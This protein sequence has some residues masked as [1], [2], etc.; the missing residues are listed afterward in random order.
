MS[1]KVNRLRRR[2]EIEQAAVRKERARLEA[3]HADLVALMREV[4]TSAAQLSK[5]QRE[6]EIGWRDLNRSAA[7]RIRV[8]RRFDQPV[9]P[10]V[11]LYITFWPD[12]YAIDCRYHQGPPSRARSLHEYADRKAADAANE[13]KNVII[14]CLT[15]ELSE[16]LR[17][18]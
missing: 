6:M 10:A 8:Q 4:E 18:K 17:A 14:A 16:Y 3:E 11:A 15:G 1:K 7:L 9:G 5:R 13:I 12:E 2:M